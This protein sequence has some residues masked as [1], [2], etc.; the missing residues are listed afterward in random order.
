MSSCELI[1][2]IPEIFLIP[3]QLLSYIQSLFQCPLGLIFDG[4]FILCIIVPK[5][6]CSLKSN[7]HKHSPCNRLCVDIFHFV[8]R[9]A[10]V[11]LSH[12]RENFLKMWNASS[13]IY[14]HMDIVWPYCVNTVDVL[15]FRRHKFL[16]TLQVFMEIQKL[17]VLFC[18]YEARTR[19]HFCIFLSHLRTQRY[20]LI[21]LSCHKFL[22]TLSIM[23][24][25]RLECP[26]TFRYNWTLHSRKLCGSRR[27]Q[28][29]RR[30]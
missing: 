22:C 13:I 11:S 8:S 10:T 29:Q 28:V 24:T 25:G 5:M 6:N 15:S 18:L 3:D 17:L 26:R 2:G 27:D 12:I 1:T 16:R 4:M 30:F 19:V 9:F 14:I 23:L 7:G 21:R 20:G